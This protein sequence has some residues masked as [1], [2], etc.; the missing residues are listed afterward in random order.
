MIHNQTKYDVFNENITPIE[1]D[2]FTL[3]LYDVFHSKKGRQLLEELHDRF[4]DK[5]IV[6]ND[7]ETQAGIR[8]GQALAVQFLKNTYERARREV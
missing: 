5:V 3:N 8:Q 4:V 6:R 7:G 2:D 1:L